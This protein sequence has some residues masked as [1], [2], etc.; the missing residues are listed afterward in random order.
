MSAHWDVPATVTTLCMV[1]A[2][3][4]A[5]SHIGARFP[6]TTPGSMR[7]LASVVVIFG[8]STFFMPLARTE[9]SV[10]GRT[11]WSGLNLMAQVRAGNL[12]FSPVAFD[13]AATY[14]LMLTALF[15]LFLP[16]PRKLLLVIALLGV[17]CSGWALEMGHDSLFHWF[18]RSGS[19]LTLL[20]V[21][22]APAMYAIEIVMSGLLLISVSETKT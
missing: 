2:V 1:F 13:V 8:L 11:E 12:R 16:R 5:L 10:L 22:Y 4:Y 17:V 3:C 20:K 18:L 14:L 9:P 21:S 19:T 15:V 6:S 7:A